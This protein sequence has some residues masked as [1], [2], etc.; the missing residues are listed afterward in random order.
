M[1]DNKIKYNREVISTDF[2][3]LLEGQ[4]AEVTYIK[5]D[6]GKLLERFII[7]DTN[8]IKVGFK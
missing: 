7:K 3:D 4:Y 1:E 2:P 8:G 5:L 6:N